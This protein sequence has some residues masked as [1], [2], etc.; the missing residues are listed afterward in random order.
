MKLAGICGSQLGEREGIKGP[1]PHLP[2]LLGHEGYGTVAACGEGVTTVEAGQDVVLHWR[3]GSGME[4]GPASYQWGGRRVSAGRVTTFQEWTVVSENRVTPAPNGVTP[5][6][7]VLLGCAATTGLGIVVRDAAVALGES[8]LVFGAGGVGGC[9]VA[10]ARAVGACRIV[11]VDRGSAKGRLVER[12][13]AD[14][15]VDAEHADSTSA[16]RSLVEPHLISCAADVVVETTG[17]SSLIE[18]GY[19][20]AGGAGRV[21]LAGVPDPARPVSIGT[22][23]LHLGRRLIGSHGGATEPEKDIP[24]YGRLLAAGRLDLTPMLGEFGTLDNVNDFLDAM[25]AGQVLGRAL[26]RFDQG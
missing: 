15:Y 5:E 26:I 24:R 14:C 20:L 2:H 4:A 9:V 7:A 11:V 10:G 17:N 1:D 23:P 12:L 13:G 18:L 21:V 25:A 3:P 8:V 22:L 16:L 6:V 19:S